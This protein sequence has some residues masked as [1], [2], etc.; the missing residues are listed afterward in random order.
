MNVHTAREI[1]RRPTGLDAISS[2]TLESL[3]PECH[4]LAIHL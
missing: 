1:F 3:T 2:L 4:N